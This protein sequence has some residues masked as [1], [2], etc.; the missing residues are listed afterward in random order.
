[1]AS[2]P[3]TASLVKDPGRNYYSIKF[4]HPRRYT[5]D[6]KPGLNVR[7]GLGT[8]DER[9]A[10]H[11]VAQM[12]QILADASLWSPVARDD[13]AKRFHPKIVDA[14]YDGLKAD[15]TDPAQVRDRLLPLP[16]RDEGYRKVL[17]VGTFGTGK[18]TL[19]RQILGTDPD[20]ERFPATSANRTTTAKLEVVLH[21]GP[22]RAVA[23]FL[24]RDEVRQYVEECLVE[25]ALARLGEGTDDEVARRLLEHR[26]QRFRLS[27]ILGTLPTKT[28]K[29]VKAFD[30]GAATDRAARRDATAKEPD[31]PTDAEREAMRKTL[32]GFIDRIRAITEAWREHAGGMQADV[33]TDELKQRY[34]EQLSDLPDFETLVNDVCAEIARRFT[35]LPGDVETDRDGWPTLWKFESSD[36][37]DF[38]RAVGRLTGNHER[39]FGRLLSPL[40]EGIRVFGPF[41]PR[42]RDNDAAPRLVLIDGEG[43]GHRVEA[44]SSVP[45]SVARRFGEVDVILL[46]D[47]ARQP[48]QTAP[49]NAVKTIVS[50]GY[51]SRLMVCFTH[52]DLVEGDNLPDDQAKMNHVLYALTNLLDKVGQDVDQ[53]A[54]QALERCLQGRVFFAA[55]LNRLGL[56]AEDDLT[57]VNLNNL[58]DAI[59]DVAEPD[60]TELRLYY[61]EHKLPLGV[62]AGLKTYHQTWRALL[63]LEARPDVPKEHWARIKAMTR[64]I[65]YLGK[66]EYFH[67]KPAANLVD[68]LIQQIS[69]YLDKPH[70][71]EPR[72]VDDEVR[73]AAIGRVKNKVYTGLLDLSRDLMIA[74]RS[75]DW[76][77]AYGFS[78][79][80]SSVKRAQAVRQILEAAAPPTEDPYGAGGEDIFA[81]IQGIVSEAVHEVGGGGR[82]VN[83]P[84]VASDMAGTA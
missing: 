49:S 75:S 36:R 24:H 68:R 31:A 76:Q 61:L 38:M 1:V 43:L 48:M 54:E 2:K 12:D 63:G 56:P 5:A 41:R 42:W 37:P 39:H 74:R 58:I 15:L 72:D 7:R 82:L 40:V 16:G 14:F 17:L 57:R 6:G 80:G 46:V 52:L 66:D 45:T 81:T 53:A 13:A 9:E 84:I 18:T 34:E 78:G 22:F 29:F 62:Q 79:A 77:A 64:H 3:Y 30:G 28:S 71:W 11:L 51:E 27:H 25:A 60:Q 4:R 20:T 47:T 70:R 23:T 59:E 33:E 35:D 10:R 8:A 44:I 69:R 26:D 67:L 55:H 19:L 83:D 50:A 65:G 21:E 73:Q 32:R